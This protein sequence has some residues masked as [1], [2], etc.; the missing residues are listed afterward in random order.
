[1]LCPFYLLIDCER[2]HLIDQFFVP[3][4]RKLFFD[5]TQDVGEHR[6]MS[7]FVPADITYHPICSFHL[8]L[9][10]ESVEKCESIVEIES[11]Q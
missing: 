7:Q 5:F 11:F 9:I 1:M 10:S 3:H 6:D 2:K 4:T 8:L